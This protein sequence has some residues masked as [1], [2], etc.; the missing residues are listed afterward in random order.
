[1]KSTGKY[2]HYAEVV[3]RQGGKDEWVVKAAKTLKKA[4]DL[5]SFGFEYITDVEGFK[6]F[7]KRK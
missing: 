2:I 6:L 3:Y 5:I 1:M 4:T 7:I